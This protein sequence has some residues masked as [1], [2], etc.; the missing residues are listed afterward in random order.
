MVYSEINSLWKQAPNSFSVYFQAVAP[1]R[2]D[3]C[4]SIA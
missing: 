2:G 4:V 3:D 1:S